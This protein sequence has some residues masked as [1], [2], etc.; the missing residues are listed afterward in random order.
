MQ[1]KNK[2]KQINLKQLD[3]I[4]TNL[5]QLTSRFYGSGCYGIVALLCVN[6]YSTYW[7]SDISF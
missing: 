2:N 3:N 6:T 4:K 5:Q 1:K 7:H